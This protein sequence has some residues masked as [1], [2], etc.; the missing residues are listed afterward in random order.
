MIFV[1][2]HG[3]VRIADDARLEVTAQR[4][5]RPSWAADSE[6]TECLDKA[7]FVGRWLA[8]AGPTATVFAQWG[9]RP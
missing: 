5:R 4:W 8:G 7:R 3:L 6:P 9:V 1:A 2:A